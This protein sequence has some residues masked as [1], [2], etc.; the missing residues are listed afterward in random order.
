MGFSC[1]FLL[2][3]NS[4]QG[5]FQNLL[6][7]SVLKWMMFIWGLWHLPGDQSIKIISVTVCSILLV[8][9]W[10]DL[11]DLNYRNAL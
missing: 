7:H 5:L 4:L 6:L 10:S 3:N 2:E 8:C 11:G 1:L 9:L